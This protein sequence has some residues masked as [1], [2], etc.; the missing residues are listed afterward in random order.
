[1]AGVLE[2]V[3]AVEWAAFGNGPIIG[4]LLG[5]LGADVIKIERRLSGDPTR[6]TKSLY[7]TALDTPQGR[8]LL[9]E[10]ANLNKRSLALD[11]SKEQGKKIVYTLIEHSDIFYTNYFEESATKIGL[12]YEA[13]SKHNSHLI[14]ASAS[15]YGSRGPD[16]SKRAFDPAV[17][18]RSGMMM[19]A[20]ERGDPPVQIVGAIVD[21]QGAL[22]T[23]L[24][25]LGAL[26]VR[27]RTGMGQR[28]EASMLAGMSWL[29]YTNFFITLM[30]GRELARHS[31]HST[32]N[33]LTN[34]YRC[35]DDK[36]ILF[37]EIQSDRYW[38]EFCEAVGIVEYQDNEG[39]SDSMRRRENAAELISILDRV[40]ASKTREEWIEIFK[41]REVH[42][43]YEVINSV[44]DM[45]HDRQMLENEF[46]VPYDHAI[47]GDVRLLNFPVKFNATPASIKSHAPELGEHTEEVLLEIGYS[48]EDIAR[49]RDEEVI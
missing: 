40:I 13:L 30:R 26:F 1:M 39:F 14:Y 44:S 31:R 19:S 43:A 3:R 9:F 25:I 22:M 7:G 45:I 28:I 42:F 5:N 6:G 10:S 18:A 27:E 11:L 16:R 8:N 48:W 34:F 29:Q 47:F 12:D 46:I 35:K 17:L 21:T 49:L 38:S 32:K 4:V 24:G 23:V 20:G 2:G 37:A 15:G 36:W 41:S 33:P